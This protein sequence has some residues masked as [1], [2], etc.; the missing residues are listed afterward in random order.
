MRPYDL[1]S[2]SIAILSGS[3]ASAE[4]RHFGIARAQL[5]G[6]GDVEQGP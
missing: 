2:G 4:E 3:A 6:D 1:Q 5:A